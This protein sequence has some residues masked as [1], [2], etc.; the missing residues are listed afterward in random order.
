MKASKLICKL[1]FFAVLIF[2][3]AV[4]SAMIY[5]NN[6]IGNEFKI[7]KGE[8]LNISSPLPVTAHYNGAKPSEGEGLSVDLKM[9]GIIPISK[10]NVQVVDRMQVALLGQQLVEQ[11]L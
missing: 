8:N 2:D 7:K 1:L 4:F 5:L 9:F 6:S 11:C 3:I 10:A